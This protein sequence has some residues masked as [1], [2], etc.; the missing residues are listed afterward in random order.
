MSTP[1]VNVKPTLLRWAIVRSRIPEEDIRAKFPRLREWESGDREPTLRQLEDFAR[2]TMTPFGHLLLSEPPDE[3]LPIPDFRTKGDTPI[4]RPSPNLI[5]TI[6]LMQQRQAWMRDYLSDLG[7]DRL[8]FVGFAAGRRDVAGVA[9]NIRETLRLSES[10]AA[11]H[12]TWE[13]ALMHLRNEIDT[14]GIL[15]AMN[16]VVGNNTHRALDP[17]EFRGFVLI[18][19][20]APL[21]FVN[22]ADF[23]AAQM[24]TLAHELAHVWLGKSALFNLI[25]MLPDGKDADEK[26]CNQVAAELLVP[27]SLMLRLWQNLQGQEKPFQAIAR[28]CKVSALVVAR[29]AL[30]LRLIDQPRFFAFYESEARQ[31]AAR[32]KAQRERGGGNFYRNAT[33][34]IGRRFGEAV[35]R[36]VA[37]GKLLYRDAYRL[38]GLKGATFDRFVGEALGGGDS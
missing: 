23:K 38:T 15:V 14:C 25:R 26:F 17:E 24:F 33:V 12:R 8:P 19:E 36:A 34:R 30:D 22:N 28:T 20:H 6:Q 35:V 4:D 10:W 13:D 9:A 31:L 37:E 18:D 5:D 16:G 27:R 2:T 3:E 21:V 1:T 7:Q 11:D 29:R 32:E